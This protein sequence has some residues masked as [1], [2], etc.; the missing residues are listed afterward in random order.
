LVQTMYTLLQQGLSIL[1]PFFHPSFALSLAQVGLLVSC[2]NAGLVISSFPSGALVDRVGE[3]WAVSAGAVIA[4]TFTLATLLVQRSPLAVGLLLFFGGL[5]SG[6]VSLS[7]S[8]AVFAWFAS[9]ER[10]LA[11]GVR[12]IAVPAGAAIGAIALPLLGAL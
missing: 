6:T 1:T 3:R 5:L 2:F 11:M 12:Q 4:C 10:G 8:K 7:S 9:D